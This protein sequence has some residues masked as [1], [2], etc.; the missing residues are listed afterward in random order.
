MYIGRE[1]EKHMLS[2]FDSKRLFNVINRF[3]DL[4]IDILTNG[5]TFNL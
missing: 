5:I 4:Y 3:T 1:D 2:H